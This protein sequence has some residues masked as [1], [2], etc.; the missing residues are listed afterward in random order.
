MP[1]KNDEYVVKPRDRVGKKK[2]SVTPADLFSS[3][4]GSTDTS[5]P[6]TWPGPQPYFG[7]GPTPAD[8]LFERGTKGWKKALTPRRKW[9]GDELWKAHVGRGLN[10]SDR[11]AVKEFLANEL[12]IT[13]EVGGGRHLM[14]MILGNLP[15]E[16]WGG[17]GY[18]DTSWFMEEYM[19]DWKRGVDQA[20]QGGHLKKDRETGLLVNENPGGDIRNPRWY[21]NFGQE[22]NAPYLGQWRPAA[23]RQREAN[24]QPITMGPTNT[25]SNLITPN[26]ATTNVNQPFYTGTSAPNAFGTSLS[27]QQG[28]I[29]SKP[30][31][32]PTGNAGWYSTWRM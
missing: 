15:D 7:K 20:I 19:P 2:K 5:T 26:V 14:N 29:Q 30:K 27:T 32:R 13:D 17:S 11:D 4:D 21:D 25:T 18:R 23:E 16:G 6:Y 8:M 31:P 1:P 24:A 12:D 10:L 9:A 22:T 28:S 3:G